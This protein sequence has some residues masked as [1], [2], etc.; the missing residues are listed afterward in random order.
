[1]AFVKILSGIMISLLISCGESS[2]DIRTG[3]QSYNRFEQDL[4]VHVMV[5]ESKRLM[6][7]ARAS[8]DDSNPNDHKDLLAWSEFSPNDASFVC[9][10]HLPKNASEKTLGHEM[11]HCLKG[12]THPEV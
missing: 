7:E 3:E 12:S 2:T 5:H 1:M 4:G 9:V 6:Q 8:V 10:I 11:L